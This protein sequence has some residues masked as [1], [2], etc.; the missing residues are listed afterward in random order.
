MSA[1]DHAAAARAFNDAYN[2][3]DWDAAIQLT[4]PNVAIANQATGQSFQGPDGVRAFLEGW[5]TAFP[6][7]QVETTSVIA[8][9]AAAAVEFHGRGTQS[10]PLAGPAGEIPPTGRAVDV[11]FV[12]VADFDAGRIARLRLYFDLATMLQQ[13]GIAGAPDAAQPAP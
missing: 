1:H 8:D 4:T 3:R 7:S 9:E 6:D 11:P 12:S 13:L 5:A 2:A 10:G